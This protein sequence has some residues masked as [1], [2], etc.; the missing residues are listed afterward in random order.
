M[1]EA[2]TCFQN[3]PVA[4]R[5]RLELGGLVVEPRDG[6][7]I[8]DQGDPADAVYA[9]FGGD[10]H[11]L[12]GSTDAR[13]KSLMAQLL[14][15][16][17][18]FGELG[19]IDGDTRS[20]EAVAI[21][22]VRLLRI[23]AELFRVILNTEPQLGAGLAKV[24]AQRLRR[25]HVLLQDAAFAPLHVRLARQLLYLAMIDGKLA[26]R[27]VRLSIRLRQADIADLLGTTSRSIITILNN[28]RARGWVEYDVA[29]AL[30]TISD[31]E[32]LRTLTEN[33]D[34]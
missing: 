27:G 34:V 2:V 14:S 21:G 28:W 29:R 13:S 6:S 17:E 19:V 33:G 3:L 16:G 25:T 7:K 31:M 23:G 10:G 1:L 26:S 32:A 4:A 20:A 15:R 12:I 5:R 9:I 30:L 11:V 8:F 22:R 18:I 24:L